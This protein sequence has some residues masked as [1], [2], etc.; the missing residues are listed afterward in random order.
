[1]RYVNL[2]FTYL[3]TYLYAGVANSAAAAGGILFFVSYIPYM[4]LQP[5]YDALSWPA[6]IVCCLVFNV[7][8]SLG[9]QVIGMFEGT[10]MYNG[11]LRW[12]WERN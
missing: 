2:P 3:L 4:F 7:A 5:R 12:I 11:V 6:K 8:M 9:C 10:G 1:M